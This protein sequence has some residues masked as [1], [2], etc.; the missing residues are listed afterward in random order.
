M[1]EV[2]RRVLVVDDDPDVRDVLNDFLTGVGYEVTTAE[3]GAKALGEVQSD[4]PDVILCDMVMPGM[5]GADVVEALR[6]AEITVPVIIISGQSITIPQGIF[7]FIGKP[8]DFQKLAHTITLA[9]EHH[10]RQGA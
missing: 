2:S 6:R 3:S 5:S 4:R 7:A 1:N 9:I 10:P 8:F